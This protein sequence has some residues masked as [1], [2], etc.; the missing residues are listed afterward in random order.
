MGAK[1]I[2]VNY[3]DFRLWNKKFQSLGTVWGRQTRTGKGRKSNR[4]PKTRKLLKK[5]KTKYREATGVYKHKNFSL[6]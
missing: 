4:W 6:N 1:A 5:A 3:K 2:C